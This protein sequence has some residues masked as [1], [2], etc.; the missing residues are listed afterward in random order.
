[1]QVDRQSERGE[2]SR[3]SQ[4]SSDGEVPFVCVCRC[5]FPLLF[6]WTDERGSPGLAF[7]PK[8]VGESWVKACLKAKTLVG[9]F[10]L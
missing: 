7:A 8:I 10:F 6:R 5:S 9:P 1:M 4:D 2:S 3:R